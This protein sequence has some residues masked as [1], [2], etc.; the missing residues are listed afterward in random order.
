MNSAY[1]LAESDTIKVEHIFTL[2]LNEKW[3]KPV[4]RAVNVFL[5]V[6]AHVAES[7]RFLAL[8]LSAYLVLIGTAKLIEVGKK[9]GGA[10]DN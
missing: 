1:G 4:R 2:G 7:F 3:D 5:D 8:G 9:K 10:S 6:G